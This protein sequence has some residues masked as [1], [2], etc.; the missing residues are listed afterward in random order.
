M[1]I[2]DIF[3]DKKMKQKDQIQ[4]ICDALIKKE[5][6]LDEL[7]D[8]S[9]SA[10]D[11]MKASCIEAVEHLT[12]KHPEFVTIQW[13][14]FVT[15]SLKDKAPRIKWESARVIGNVAHLFPENIET[16]IENL[17]KNAKH[18]GTVVRWSSA[19]AIGK[20][21]ESSNRNA[22]NLKIICEELLKNEEK[23]SI[24]KLY[25]RAIKMTQSNKNDFNS[26]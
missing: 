15:E 20:I 1:N 12:C 25:F 13:L 5:L 19:F 18:S 21:I 7:L 8:F 11:S 10:K 22:E 24:Q 2:A 14:N 9:K 4:L 6:S 3:R 16:A 26:R 17:L 23:N